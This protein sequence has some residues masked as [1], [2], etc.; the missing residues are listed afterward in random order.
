MCDTHASEIC[1]KSQHQGH[2]AEAK[3][4]HTVESNPV[5]YFFILILQKT[6]LEWDMS[7]LDLNLLCL[8]L[9]QKYHTNVVK[10]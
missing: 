6:S 2:N 1:A 10:E 5:K 4:V 8:K 9:L 7:V 3:L